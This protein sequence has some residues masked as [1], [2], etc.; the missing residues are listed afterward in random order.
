MARSPAW[1]NAAIVCTLI[2]TTIVLSVLC[3]SVGSV[4]IPIR[5]VLLSLIGMNGEGSNLIIMQFRLPRIVAALLIGA[6]LAVSGSLLQGVIRNPLASPDLLG[7]T[8]GASV[9][10]VA[11]M[12]VFTG[13][14]IHFVPVVAIAGAFAAAALNYMFAWK[15]GVTP[16]RLVLIGTEYRRR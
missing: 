6:A 12:T 4:S 7:V 16:S 5:E 3:L 14:S 2:V 11:F 10:V 9:A 8:G 15:K 1:K 13:Y